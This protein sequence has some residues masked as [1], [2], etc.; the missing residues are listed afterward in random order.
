MSTAANPEPLAS[1][2]TPTTLWPLT[3]RQGELSVLCDALRAGVPAIVITGEAGI[4]KTRLA[5][6]G[7]AVLAAEGLTA[8]WTVASAE[9]RSISLGALAHLLERRASSA[10]DGDWDTLASLQAG[11][12]ERQGSAR[13]V[14]AVDDA[15]RLDAESASLVSNLARAGQPPVLLTVRSGETLPEE[16]ANL[17]SDPNVLRLDLAPLQ[18][19][20]VETLVGDFLGEVDPASLHQLWDRSGGNPLWL[21]ELVLDGLDNGRLAQQVGG[22]TWTW[23]T[24]Q[25]PS[26]RLVDLLRSRLSVVGD[27]ASRWMHMIAL[28]EPMPGRVALDVMG[29]A[30]IS[31]LTETGLIVRD[32]DENDE[33][34]RFSHPLFGDILRSGTP[35]LRTRNL[36]REL[37]TALPSPP[38]NPGME[39][40][41]LATWYLGAE[42]EMP[43][44]LATDAAEDAMYH[45]D[46]SLAEWIARA[47]L[48][49]G[50]LWN[51]DP[52]NAGLLA[53]VLIDALSKLG[54]WDEVLER[55]EPL[56]AAPLDGNQRARLATVKLWPY[57]FLGDLEAADA[58]LAEAAAEASDTELVDA[59]TTH[60]ASVALMAGEVE[61]CHDIAWGL[62]GRSDLD[63]F[64]L[65]WAVRAVGAADALAGRGDDVIA[66]CARE[67]G[68]TGIG[69]DYFLAPEELMVGLSLA[70]WR[71]GRLAQGLEGAQSYHR[72]ALVLNG[73]SRS[74]VTHM[75][76]GIALL[77]CGQLEAARGPLREAVAVMERH[78]TLF[79]LPFAC[80]ELA[81]AHATVG[82]F[83]AATVALATMDRAAS[84]P[85]PVFQSAL[86]RAHAW[87]AAAQG[88]WA[89]GVSILLDAAERIG[90]Q[91]QY[92]QQATLLHDVVRFGQPRRVADELA[93]LAPRCDG[94]LIAHMAAHANGLVGSDP[95][96]VAAAARGLTE[97]GAALQAAEAWD[98]AKVLYTAARCRTEARHAA[99]EVDHLVG[100]CGNPPTLPTRG[101]RV[102][103]QLTA[104]EF[105][106]ATLARQGLSDHDIA[107]RI[108]CSV[109]TVGNH[110][111]RVYSKLD[112]SG[113]DDLTD[114]MG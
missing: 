83:G 60:R 62:L 91:H 10:A 31:Q 65:R 59:A 63:D 45:A 82:D 81:R 53:V 111:S 22:W 8:E 36:W 99:A 105:E 87:N 73:R 13:M 32:G 57:I 41:R 79:Y 2:P 114:A 110:L 15:H 52:T 30:G 49:S 19:E 42:L 113:R 21:R 48:D 84:P 75:L 18:E 85:L 55:M 56:A 40:R 16:L 44:N 109:R 102:T 90:A 70:W 95:A 66:L 72:T 88:D 112:L 68:R 23:N 24:D 12:A 28:A 98:D 76:V 38:V 61:R 4:G 11:L 104:R 17:V 5:R 64:S 47:A 97:C 39:D 20:E 94:P 101:R 89:T 93:R 9:A 106:I 58:F 3:G 77:E 107:G 50:D 92:A 14:L 108:G 86:D 1:P 103:H 69:S 43:P 37:V 46:P 33:T 74:A 29:P 71:S 78:Q 34:L 54:R 96:A 27:Q 6:E 7:L 80:G 100:R 35:P 26:D 25:A 67:L 51:S